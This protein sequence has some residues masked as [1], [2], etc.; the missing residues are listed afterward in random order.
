MEAARQGR[1]TVW[2]DLFR[3]VVFVVWRA[4]D[5]LPGQVGATL[6]LLNIGLHALNATMVTGLAYRLGLSSLAGGAAGAFFVCFPASVEAVA[7]P[8]GIQD[9]LMTSFVLAFLLVLTR[10]RL[11]MAGVVGAVS[12]LLAACL[13]KE[14]GVTAIALAVLV[15][16]ATRA[17]RG[18]WVVAATSAAAV[19]VLLIVRFAHLPF[20]R[21]FAAP[22]SRYEVKELLVRPFG[23]L[24]VP[25][26]AAEAS[27]LPWLAPVLVAV[28]V[29][30]L[31][32]TARRWH[33]RSRGFHLALFGASFALCSLAAVNTLFFITDD[34]LGSRYLYLGSAGWALMLATILKG[35]Q[36]APWVVRRLPAVVLLVC[37]AV[38]TN[39]HVRLWK[40]AGAHREVILSAADKVVMSGCRAPAVR[41]LPAVIAGVPLFLNGFPEAMSERQPT[42]RFHMD[43]AAAGVDCRLAWTGLDFQKE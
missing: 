13:T 9:V 37:W 29:S 39:A 36:D 21:A 42:S 33:P 41:G 3:P 31:L 35:E 10:P 4:L 11:T 40:K 17:P 22:L 16:A 43:A 27:A 6:H 26:R 12:L 28:V 20:P 14:T 8:A 23:T 30:A 38:A 34:L 7:W 19:V 15:C 32:L 24:L 2:T 5:A 1:L 18:P 25:L